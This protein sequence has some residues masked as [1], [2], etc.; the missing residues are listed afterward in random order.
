MSPE[1][2][3]RRL[4]G[5]LHASAL[6][7]SEYRPWASPPLHRPWIRTLSTPTASLSLLPVA[8]P[9]VFMVG[10]TLHRNVEQRW[11][12]W[13]NQRSLREWCG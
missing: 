6:G 12:R 1:R 13:D 11:R 2:E 5:I 8:A 7:T 3:T 9:H 4:D 10:I